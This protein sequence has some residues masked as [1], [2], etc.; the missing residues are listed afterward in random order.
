MMSEDGVR[1]INSQLTLAGSHLD[2]AASAET[3][4]VTRDY[5]SLARNIYEE[6]LRLLPIV[7]VSGRE[8]VRLLMDVAR[9]RDR[10]RECGEEV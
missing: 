10:L 2:R 9:L 3:P 5:T 4:A 8:R 6:V 1:G 7:Q